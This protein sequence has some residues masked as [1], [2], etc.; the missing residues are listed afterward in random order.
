ME[1]ALYAPGL[2]Y[3]TAGAEKLGGA[4]DFITAPELTTLF[5]ATLARQVAQVLDRVGGGILE[6]GAGSGRLAVDLL[7]ALDGLNVLPDRYRILDLSAD[8]VA[9]QRRTLADLPPHLRERV[10]WISALPEDLR[11]VVLGNEVL[12]ALPVHLV[13]R[14]SNE[15]L[16][17]GVVWHEDAL[18]WQQRP[19]T[20]GALATRANGI[21]ASA[22][23]LTEI[24]L[25]AD[26]LVRELAG[27]LSQGMLL[28]VDYGFG[29]REY[30]H[31]QRT[32]GTLMCHYRHR[33]HADPFFLPGLQDITAHVD[34][35]AVAAAG[36][37]AGLRLAG[38]TSQ[39]RL[40]AN[41]GITTLM[42]SVQP[43]TDAWLKRVAP[44]QKLLSPA[45]MGELFKALALTRGVE[46]PLAGF[47]LG[48]LDRLL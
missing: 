29:A 34:F 20:I 36:V 9:R 4:G 12:D 6:L 16:E 18:A 41:L 39:A 13:C 42:T 8:L 10:T 37:G 22:P 48:S 43:G 11:G 45:E 30:Y 14:T 7:N 46:I 1:T 26:A 2:G 40:L 32:E 25:A 17:R 44:V 3:Y 21:P 19:I 33:A 24:N 31:P 5:G 35:S 23:Y 15:W 38:Y 28:F 27:R 47:Q